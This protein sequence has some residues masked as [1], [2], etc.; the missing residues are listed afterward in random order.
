MNDVAASRSDRSRKVQSEDMLLALF[1]A[2]EAVAA[3]MAAF[4]KEFGLTSQQYNV[5]RVLYVGE[6]MPLQSIGGRLI[7][8]VPDVSRLIDRLSS[9]GLVQRVRCTQDKRVVFVELTELGRQKMAEVDP[10]LLSKV[11]SLAEPL[12]S[13][14]QEQLISLLEKLRGPL[15]SEED[16]A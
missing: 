6:K 16:T 12:S 3:P 14:E 15:E 8:R 9:A 1:R 4:F 11:A 10:P 2:H 13:E 5:L 7:T